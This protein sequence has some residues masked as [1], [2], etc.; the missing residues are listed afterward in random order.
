[1]LGIAPAIWVA[2]G[3]LGGAFVVFLALVGNWMTHAEVGIDPFAGLP[4]F[5]DAEAQALLEAGA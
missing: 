5:D 3:A 2:L 4:T 1:M